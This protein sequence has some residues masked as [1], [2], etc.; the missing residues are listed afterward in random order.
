MLKWSTST[1]TALNNKYRVYTVVKGL[2]TLHVLLWRLNAPFD[3]GFQRLAT[4]F[5]ICG[6]IYARRFCSAYVEGLTL[7]V[8]FL[9]HLTCHSTGLRCALRTL[10][11]CTKTAH[12]Q[13]VQI[14]C[15]V[16]C[17][18]FNFVL[19]QS[20]PVSAMKKINEYDNQKYHD[21]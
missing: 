7:L 17:F 5:R 4:S 6:R 19:S 8:T 13:H 2:V 11:G 20:E 16:G 1:S 10:A 9:D 3:T 14:R 21:E 18:R 15:T 12:V